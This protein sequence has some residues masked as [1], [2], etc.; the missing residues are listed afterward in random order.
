MRSG[1][2]GGDDP[3]DHG[4]TRSG[5]TLSPTNDRKRSW[6]RFEAPRPNEWWQI[7]AMDWTI[8]T[9]VVKVFNII[10][11]H[12]RVAPRSWACLDATG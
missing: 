2:V 5:D 1:A 11:D 4:P 8:A 12:S 3:S 10:D 7:D 6:H 9:G